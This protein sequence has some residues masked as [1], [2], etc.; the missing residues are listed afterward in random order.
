MPAAQA[1]ERFPLNRQDDEATVEMI[2]V[3]KANTA[4]LAVWD[5]YDEQVE[6]VVTSRRRVRRESGFF[7]P[8]RA[9]EDNDSLQDENEEEQ[10]PQ[11]SQQLQQHDSPQDENSM[12]DE[13]S[14]Q[15]SQQQQQQQQQQQEGYVLHDDDKTSED[16]PFQHRVWDEPAA[17]ILSTL[18]ASCAVVASS[19]SS[20]K[21]LDTVVEDLLRCQPT[22]FRTNLAATLQEYVSQLPPDNETRTTTIREDPNLQNLFEA[23]ART[24]WTE[25]VANLWQKEATT[26]L[27]DYDR[28]LLDVTN[29]TRSLESDTKPTSL[30]RAIAKEQ[31]AVDVLEQDLANAK[32]H[33][34]RVRRAYLQQ[35]LAIALHAPVLHSAM[36]AMLYFRVEQVHEDGTLEISFSTAVQETVVFATTCATGERLDLELRSC[37]QQ[38]NDNVLRIPVDH[39]AAHVHRAILTSLLEDHDAADMTLA[40]R[41]LFVS[42]RVA[43][44]DSLARDLFQFS[45]FH[46]VVWDS[47]SLTLEGEDV[48]TLEF[49]D[50]VRSCSTLADASF[51]LLDDG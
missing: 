46:K 6:D 35:Q 37:S 18:A 31:A 40:E 13:H 5:D 47:H 25:L 7:Q 34:Q 15:A 27:H 49:E 42:V 8:Y 30:A 19:K 44:V 4:L 33:H 36:D 45:Q 39:V 41:L 26:L 12:E 2:R 21:S 32:I 24:E 9:D 29:A 3:T 43:R 16:F 17:E 28:N 10:S 20:T 51:R 50:L 38:R 11:A 23:R 1:A 14:P 48:V 22:F